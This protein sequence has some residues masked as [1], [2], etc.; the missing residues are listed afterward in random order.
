MSVS[1]SSGHVFGEYHPA[2]ATVT[3]NA[4]LTAADAD[5]EV[6]HLE[7]ATADLRRAPANSE[8]TTGVPDVLQ[9]D[10]RSPLYTPGDCL[11]VLPLPLAESDVTR[12]RDAT[13]TVLKRA[14]LAPDAW[15]T[16]RAAGGH[17]EFISKPVRAA[18]LVEG[19]FDLT[20]ASARRYFFEVASTFASHPQE[21]ERLRHFAGKD[22]R[23]E[24][25]YYNERERR[26]VGEFLSDFPSVSMPL[27]WML[28]TAPRLRHRLF[29]IASSPLPHPHALH[30]TV[31]A[32]RWKTH[33]G[34]V[35]EGLCSNALRR[36]V[37][38]FI[39]IRAIRLTA[40]VCFV[41]VQRSSRRRAGVLARPDLHGSTEGYHAPGIGV[42]R[43]RG[44]AAQGVRAGT[45]PQ[46]TGMSN[47]DCAHVGILRLPEKSG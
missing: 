4:P 35:R 47:Q 45:G 33:Y 8:S 31:T 11:A 44:G 9:A 29:S 12:A 34:R 14:G 10:E 19:A 22:G 13:G 39:F 43:V 36:C 23:D 17:S 26:S 27:E 38:T 24:L 15:V 32:A 1:S 2:V 20:S 7:V 41:C 3:V 40:Q 5:A 28:T 21:A 42:H 30:L 46:G 16:L 6:R 25:W 18:S 37:S